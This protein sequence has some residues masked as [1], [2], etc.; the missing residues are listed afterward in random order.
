MWG[1]SIV[2]HVETSE[3]MS[4]FYFLFHFSIEMNKQKIVNK[5]RQ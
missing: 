5:R 2:H 1:S 4:F 3:N